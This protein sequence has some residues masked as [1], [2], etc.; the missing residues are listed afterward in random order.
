[1]LVPQIRTSLSFALAAGLLLCC[2]G[3]PTHAQKPSAGRPKAPAKKKRNVKMSTPLFRYR[4]EARVALPPETPIT[5]AAKPVMAPRATAEPGYVAM[6][7]VNAARNSRSGVNAPPSPLTIR[8]RS[9]LIASN[10]PPM[11]LLA[12]ADRVVAYGELSW[13]LF[14]SDGAS[15][16]HAAIGMGAVTLDPEWNLVYY[17]DKFGRVAANQ[18]SDGASAFSLLPRQTKGF[19]RRLLTR[20]EHSLFAVSY[21]VPIDAHAADPE[22]SIAE[23]FDLIGPENRKSW[24][25]AGGPAV[26]QDA[27]AKSAV[28]LPAMRKD[29][30]VLALDNVI[31]TLDPR[32]EVRS[33]LAGEFQPLAFSLDEARRIYLLLGA[34]GKMYLWRIS[35]AGERLYSLVLP[36]GFDIVAS[37]PIVGYDHTVYLVSGRF[38]LSVAQDGKLNW[39]RE[40]PTA[41]AG[42]VVTP[43]NQLIV[44]EGANVTVWNAKGDRTVLHAFPEALVTA[45]VLT[46]EGALFVAS[47]TT[48][49]CASR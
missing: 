48:L 9:P 42:A 21:E 6:Q 32:L 7:F 4:D 26:V 5:P 18:L 40:A 14:Q 27:V 28:M 37:P 25:D 41:I 47:R 12:A 10:Q 2:A 1:M 45:P 44:S 15:L 13:Q 46:K 11:V 43:D 33:V 8:W 38:I 23:S 30:L 22:Y 36:P 24:L 3:D 16:G 20:F 29:S 17:P 31:Y 39:S 49:Y 34:G 19:A 35:P